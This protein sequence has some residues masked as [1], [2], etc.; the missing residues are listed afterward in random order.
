MLKDIK[1][2]LQNDYINI[3]RAIKFILADVV[4]TVFIYSI[5]Y[6]SIMSLIQN[7]FSKEKIFLYTSIILIIMIIRI[8]TAK[9]AMVNIQKKGSSAVKNLRIRI[10]DHIRNLNLGYFH[11]N[12]IGHLINILTLNIS[13]FEMVIT[14]TT[15]DLLK[16]IILSV[17]FLSVSFFINYKL[18]L[19]QFLVFILASP[20]MYFGGKKL[21]QASTKKSIV[22]SKGMAT[23]VEYISGIELFKSFGISGKKFKRLENSFV[24]FKKYSIKVE[25]S[26]VPYVL[27]FQIIIDLMFP[28]L[29][30]I[31]TTMFINKNLTAEMLIAFT[32][33][34]LAFTNIVRGFSIGYAQLRYLLVSMEKLKETLNYPTISYKEE[35]Y[36]FSNYDIEF[37]NVNFSYVD[38]KKVLNNINFVAKEKEITA[39]VGESGSGKSTIITLIARFWDIQNGSIKIGGKNIKDINPE[40]LLKN[41]SMV[42]QDVYLINDT[43]YENIKIGNSNASYEEIINAA[44][45]ANCHNFIEKMENSY[46]T[47]IG[48]GGSTLSG[49]EKQRISIAR[50]FLKN[51]PIILLDE[52]TASLD[53]DNEYEIKKSIKKLT[54]NK[55]VIV[56]AHRLNTIQ[57]ADKIIVMEEGKILEQ[58]KHSELMENKNKYFNMFTEMSKAKEWSI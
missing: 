38:D 48:E 46:D 6:F 14:H 17:Y 37:K 53:A 25:L 56:I 35:N 3:K 34:N 43:V 1:F 10:G 42:F 18:A 22:F 39:L 58:G 50:A 41:I 31:S 23:I 4:F 52:A 57:D 54:A 5:L 44:K 12:N 28:L 8:F 9:Y 21:N 32:I 30:I 33:L 16:V 29:L 19:I 15:G 7:N 40:S 49:G 45:L 47:V 36:N 2:I 24:D 55:T 27:L 20:I 51:A 26:A 11:K 13:D